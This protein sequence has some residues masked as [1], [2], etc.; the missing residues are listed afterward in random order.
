MAPR[1]LLKR[2]L[3][4]FI[5]LLACAAC[6]AG[7]KE[8]LTEAGFD[9]DSFANDRY[10]LVLCFDLRDDDKPSAGL[11]VR[12]NA[13]QVTE[14]AL[15]LASQ[16]T[17]QPTPQQ[18]PVIQHLVVLP[19]GTSGV[20]GNRR[21]LTT[22]A[23][24]N[25]FT[26]VTYTSSPQNLDI[27]GIGLSPIFGSQSDSTQPIVHRKENVYLDRSG[28]ERTFYYRYPSA[29]QSDSK[30]P[31][32]LQYLPIDVIDAIGVAL[33][34]NARGL[35][36]Q[37]NQTAIPNNEFD[38]GRA[39]FY[40]ATAQSAKTS[41]LEVRYEVEA[42]K[43]QRI[44][45]EIILKLLAAFSVPLVEL[46]LLGPV[47][48]VH[49]RTRKIVILSGVILQLVIVGTLIWISLNVRGELGEKTIIE[50]P[51]IVLSAVFTGL[52]LYIKRNPKG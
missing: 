36:I 1:G 11:A 26:M 22:W 40:P 20:Q 43:P 6:M 3:G 47:D 12:G 10:N 21:L 48:I 38:N 5:G 23:S 18:P 15:S 37:N 25:E 28:L 45:A 32:E 27:R 30:H 7:C 9:H 33:P 35:E 51:I 44:L 2:N 50:L 39:K 24:Y 14:Q 46:V 42:S 41:F 19:F 34:A 8:G 31:S 17:Q 13:T 52:V 16:A 49:P 29:S 4:V